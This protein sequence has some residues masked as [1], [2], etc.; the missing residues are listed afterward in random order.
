MYLA[1]SFVPDDALR[2]QVRQMYAS[3]DKSEASHALVI[4]PLLFGFIVTLLVYLVLGTLNSTDRIKHTVIGGAIALA[5]FYSFVPYL[6]RKRRASD[7]E[8][9][10]RNERL[11]A[12]PT[13]LRHRL[14]LDERC[15]FARHEH[16]LV[17]IADAGEGRSYVDD[18]S[19]IADHPWHEMAWNIG[20]GAAVEKEW[21]W[22]TTAPDAWPVSL[23]R[24]GP[25][26]Q[27][28]VLQDIDEQLSKVY[29]ELEMGKVHSTSYEQLLRQLQ[30]DEQ[31]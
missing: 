4:L 7:T 22:I 30:Q 1:V 15:C 28:Q 14:V 31:A 26:A 3:Q 2:Q 10:T 23:Q 24:S 27:P 16:G 21:S 9:A 29:E 8:R 17:I 11:A 19:T 25:L 12:M 18:I 13:F 20:K 5:A 6:K